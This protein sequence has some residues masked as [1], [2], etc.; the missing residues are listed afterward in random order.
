MKLKPPSLNLP[1]QRSMQPCCIQGAHN[2]NHADTKS[3]SYPRDGPHRV[4]GRLFTSETARQ[5]ATAI[6]NPVHPTVL[7]WGG[8]WNTLDSF[9]WSHDINHGSTVGQKRF[10]FFPSFLFL[11][12]LK[13]ND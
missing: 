4:I 7:A 3:L 8:A 12:S 5:H 2:F 6:R 1:S 10:L 13:N 9:V 11:L